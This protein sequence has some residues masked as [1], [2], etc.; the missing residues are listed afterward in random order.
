MHP[1]AV[2]GS[3][4]VRWL[5]PQ[6]RIAPGQSLVAYEHDEVAGGATAV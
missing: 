6:R 4:I 1:T 2:D 5:H 3:A